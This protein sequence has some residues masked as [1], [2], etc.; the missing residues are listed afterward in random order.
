MGEILRAVVF[1]ALRYL[2]LE[3]GPAAEVALAAPEERLEKAACRLALSVVGAESGI[4]DKLEF[5]AL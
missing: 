4:V 1:S 3:P 5:E 2:A